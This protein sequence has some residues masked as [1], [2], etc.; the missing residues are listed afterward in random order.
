[1]KRCLFFVLILMFLSVPYTFAEEVDWQE[2]YLELMVRF[3]TLQ[4]DLYN[5]GQE[6]V[7]WKTEVQRL[8]KAA[9]QKIID[10]A[11]KDLEIYLKSKSDTKSVT[12]PTVKPKAN[13]E[14]GSSK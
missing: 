6:N 11:N 8:N 5:C 2:K 4:V 12:E 9:A 10:K 7:L 3:R 1:M 13:K 14:T